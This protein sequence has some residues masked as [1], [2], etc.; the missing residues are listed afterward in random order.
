MIVVAVLIAFFATSIV[1]TTDEVIQ[2]PIFAGRGVEQ[3]TFLHAVGAIDHRLGLVTRITPA[4][5]HVVVVDGGGF[6]ACTADWAV[7]Q[8]YTRRLFGV[9]VEH[10][11]LDRAVL[12]LVDTIALVANHITVVVDPNSP[13]VLQLGI[14]LARLAFGQWYGQGAAYFAVGQIQRPVC[15]QIA[16]IQ[17][18]AANFTGGGVTHTVQT[19]IDVG[20]PEGRRRLDHFVTATGILVGLDQLVE[21]A[22]AV[23]QPEAGLGVEARAVAVVAILAVVTGEA[24]VVGLGIDGDVLAGGSGAGHQVLAVIQLFDAGR[25]AQAVGAGAI[26]EADGVALLDDGKCGAQLAIHL[27]AH[28]SACYVTQ[29]GNQTISF[30]AD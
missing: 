13:A 23:E 19:A 21:G 28:A 4:H 2:I 1:Q 17:V 10:K 5:D 11:H 30:V 8:R 9:Q 7:L 3:E 20:D 26:L 25:H 27:V 22:C 24:P 16:A 15:R 6:R 18:V 29:S 14:I 12:T